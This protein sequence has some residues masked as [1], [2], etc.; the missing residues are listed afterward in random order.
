M[1]STP[2]NDDKHRFS[3]KSLSISLYHEACEKPIM[4]AFNI[5]VSSSFSK[6]NV[7]DTEILY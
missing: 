4:S 1:L 3:S 2:C 6:L 7:A 5:S